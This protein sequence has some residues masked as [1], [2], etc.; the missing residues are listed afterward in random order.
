MYVERA[1]YT[2]FKT[3]LLEIGFV[4]SQADNSLFIHHEHGHITYL[5]LYA[6]NIILTG[7]SRTSLQMFI[8]QL[9]VHFA[10][11]V[12]GYLHYFL[13]IEFVRHKG[14]VFLSR[15]NTF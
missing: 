4:N 2:K 6:G 5:L 8:N 3:H 11:K 1:W 13:G 14:R 10:T 9:R 7:T 15:T 12:L